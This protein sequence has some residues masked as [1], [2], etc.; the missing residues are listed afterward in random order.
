MSVPEKKHISSA[1]QFELGK[2]ETR[3]VRVRMLEHLA[4][5]NEVLASQVAAALGEVVKD[6]K[7]TPADGTGVAP[8]LADF[9]K[10]VSETTASGG[11]QR[12][13]GLS[14]V[15]KPK[16]PVD[17][18]K[19][20]KVAVLVTDG[21]P[22]EQVTAFKEALVAAGAKA[23]VL[24]SHLGQVKGADGTAVA[25]DKTFTTS[26]SV[27][28]DAVFIPGGKN[29]EA[30]RNQGPIRYFIAEAYKH[31]KPVVTVDEGADLVKKAITLEGITEP[32]SAKKA[33][34]NR[35]LG[36]IIGQGSDVKGLV[37][38][39]LAAFESGRFYD[40]PNIE[41]MAV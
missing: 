26:G 40:R 24:A 41:E 37:G 30:L 36:L 28:Y 19:T 39:L 31:G 7:V 2:V 35:S 1:L 15:E 34:D 22:A 18:V 25:V 11:L 32:E 27:M 29:A 13:S 10:A 6:G 16:F 33:P 23:E 17:N 12:A 9:S 3:E 20:R 8:A 38:Q 5:I 14:L 21:V 4:R